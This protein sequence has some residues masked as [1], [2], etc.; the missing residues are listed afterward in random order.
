MKIVVASS[1]FVCFVFI[2]RKILMYICSCWISYQLARSALSG[3]ISSH[4]WSADPDIHKAPSQPL[5]RSW[6]DGLVAWFFLWVSKM[7]EVLGSIPSQAL[8][9]LFVFLAS[10]DITIG[11]QLASF[12]INLAIRN[13]FS[14]L[15]IKIKKKKYKLERYGSIQDRT[16][17]LLWTQ[18]WDR[19]HNH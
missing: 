9:C 6:P 16:G 11:N 2:F 10:H 13:V 12:S 7:E 17:D 18:M 19:N 14:G 4:Q 3:I 5:D 1:F 15:L 8:F